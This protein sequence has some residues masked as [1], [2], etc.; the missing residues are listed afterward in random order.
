MDVGIAGDVFVVSKD[1]TA[2][3]LKADPTK[4]ISFSSMERVQL[5]GDPVVMRRFLYDPVTKEQ[6][7]PDVLPSVLPK[8]IRY[9][10]IPDVLFLSPA[11]AA[12]AFHK[13][14]AEMLRQFPSMDKVMFVADEIPR[15]MIEGKQYHMDTDKMEFRNVANPKDT[16]E[17]TKIMRL[18]GDDILRSLAAAIIRA[19]R[20]QP[21][22]PPRQPPGD[23][24]SP[25]PKGP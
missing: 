4:R 11:L 19:V 1:R 20:K 2:L 13:S 12:R 23:D 21:P 25:K 15:M 5:S 16:M 9:I 8:D 6:Y 3:E 18:T 17:I 7:K 22:R 24:N 10:Q 14:P